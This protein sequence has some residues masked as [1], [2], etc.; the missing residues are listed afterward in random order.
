M[1]RSALRRTARLKAKRATPRRA[2]NRCPEL[3]DFVRAHFCCV[4][5]RN[6][7]E[8]A[9]VPPPS[10]AAHVHAR[11]NGGDVANVV[12]LC[13]VHHEE[14]HRIGVRSFTAKYGLNLEA[15]ARDYWARWLEET[16]ISAETGH[17]VNQS[18]RF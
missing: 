13:R 12:P 4:C 2:K 9:R 10:E 3:L 17:E 15:L 1:K 18:R 6:G 8:Y 5:T 16:V 7:R 11:R 14:Q